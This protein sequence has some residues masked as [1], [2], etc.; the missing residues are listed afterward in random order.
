MQKKK[1]YVSP[2]IE[3]IEM[4]TKEEMLALSVYD[5]KTADPNEEVL[6]NKRRGKWGDLWADK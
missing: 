6:S 3:V 1:E 2:S 4:E 5:D